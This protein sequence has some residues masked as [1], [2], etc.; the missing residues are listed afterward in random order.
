M[1][2]NIIVQV[3][4][5]KRARVH[6][7]EMGEIRT[8]DVRAGE[9]QTIGAQS[10]TAMFTIVEEDLDLESEDHAAPGVPISEAT[11]DHTTEI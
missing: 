7:T 4:A 6:V 10:R 3:P 2:T 8:I 9:P 11:V 5:G 1:D